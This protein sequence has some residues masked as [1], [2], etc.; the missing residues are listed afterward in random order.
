MLQHESLSILQEIMSVVCIYST[1]M[2]VYTSYLSQF[3]FP[4]N[5][6]LTAHVAHTAR[7]SC[8]AILIALNEILMG[9]STGR[10]I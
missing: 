2:C 10:V 3:T 4:T 8:F 7:D 9:C 6:Y 1:L 5:V